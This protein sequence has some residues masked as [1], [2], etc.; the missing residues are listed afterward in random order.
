MLAPSQAKAQAC[1]AAGSA[2]TPGRL[3]MH[4]KELVGLALHGSSVFG[5]FDTSSHYASAPSGTREIDLEQDLFGAVR[6]FRRGQVALLVPFVETH[7]RVPG[8]S[9]FG[10]GIGDINLSVRW[11]FLFAGQS[12][13]MPGIAVLAGVTVPTGR[14]P[15]S[16]KSELAADATGVGAYQGNLGLALE[17]SFGPWL[18]NLSAIVSKRTTRTTQGVSST[19]GAQWLALGAVAYIFEGGASVAVVG[20]YTAEGRATIDSVEDPHSGRRFLRTSLTGLVPISDEMRA[21][22]T[23]F[24]DPPISGLGRNTPTSTGLTFTWVYAWS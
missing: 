11:D 8:T 1:C 20:A 3:A 19:L 24:V 17:Q 21:L 7:R 14:P 6:L 12:E 5:R 15:E 2:L 9:A 16:A 4:E 13:V 23:L 22:G 18:V 10:G